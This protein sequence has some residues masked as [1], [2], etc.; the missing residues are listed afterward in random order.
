MVLLIEPSVALT[1]IDCGPAG[2]FTPVDRLDV[3]FRLPEAAGAGIDGHVMAILLCG[4][5]AP[6]AFVTSPASARVIRELRQI[7]EATNSDS[8]WS[9]VR[10]DSPT[11]VLH[12]RGRILN[13]KQKY[14]IPAR[15]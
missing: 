9:F 4:R 6:G 2:C 14:G 3:M 7:S 12:Q 15:N 13:A 5:P 11:F 10:T 1:R 8:S